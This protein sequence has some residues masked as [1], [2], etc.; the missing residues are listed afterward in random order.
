M[1]KLPPAIL[2]FILFLTPLAQGEVTSFHNAG[3]HITGEWDFSTLQET[4]IN[5]KDGFIDT[6][7]LITDDGI[8]VLCSGIMD[9]PTKRPIKL[10]YLWHL[11]SSGNVLWSV[12]I[13]DTM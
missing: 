11:D 8:Y 13:N 6:Q 7:P 2:L 4:T 10:P 12:A 1:S 3:W 5:M 9:F